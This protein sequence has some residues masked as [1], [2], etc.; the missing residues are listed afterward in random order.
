LILSVTLLL[1]AQQF[2]GD[3]TYSG[4]HTDAA[5][6]SAVEKSIA[7]GV[8]VEG[9]TPLN[10]E[11]FWG[12]FNVA[13]DVGGEVAKASAFYQHKIV[14]EKDGVLHVR[15]GSD[16]GIKV[17]LNGKLLLS[18]NI[19][20]G[21]NPSEEHI[22]LPLVDGEN[23][24]AIGIL[25][26]GGAWSFSINSE[27]SP[28]PIK[29]DRAI[30]KG[31]DWLI[32]NQL[33]DGSWGFHNNA[34]RN[35]ATSLAVYTL[36]SCGVSPQSAAVQKGLSYIS[37]TY[38]EK[39]YSAGC[40]LMALAELNDSRYYEQMEVIASDLIS[41][42]ERNGM[43]AYPSGHWDLS[44]TQFA[45]LG[46]RA[47][48]EIGIAVPAKVWRDAIEGI[49]LCG[50]QFD[51]STQPTIT[52]FKYYPNYTSSGTL[53]MTAAAIASIEICRQ[54]LDGKYPQKIRKKVQRAAS[55]GMAWM[56]QNFTVAQNF[57]YGSSHHYYTLYGIERV[58]AVHDITHFGEHNWYN[59]GA[60]FL[61]DGQNEDGYWQSDIASLP[62]TLYSL[63]FLKRATASAA[64]TGENDV[65]T[66]NEV[67]SEDLEGRLRLHVNNGDPAV[68]WTSLPAGAKSDSV[69]YF[70]KRARDSLWQKI[71]TSSAAKF[72]LSR[73][74]AE[75]GKWLVKA[76]CTIG[77][78]IVNSTDVTYFFVP[79]LGPNDTGYGDDAFENLIPAC[80]P[81]YEVS[82][83]NAD[84]FDGDKLFDGRHSTRWLTK[85][86]DKNPEFTISLRKTAKTKRLLFSHTYTAPINCTGA[87]RP[88][89]VAVYINKEE[90]PLIIPINP[91]QTQ[92]TIYTFSETVRIKKLRVVV[93]KV[94]GGTLGSSAIGFSEVELQY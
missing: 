6:I 93:T 64:I 83:R 53:S 75:P 60:G 16:D 58:G 9:F 49:L 92:K 55:E 56:T 81:S 23:Q 57:G 35:G 22:A 70:I 25:N 46:L 17:W 88:E 48:A 74:L 40:Q 85:P 54:Q 86:N 4:P 18:H 84:Y 14:A 34:Y 7:T 61:V 27:A 32:Q 39:T 11:W 59:N 28:N 80:R 91:D 12:T 3:W 44:C 21:L 38:P 43:W 87:A 72:A 50:A 45:I 65:S 94:I 26:T 1:Y 63:L 82:S 79:N 66:G 47:A 19:D 33:V 73:R 36:L 20:R 37:A 89:E 15:M 30:R 5:E 62:D 77:G 71:G 31:T 90:E 67:V 69:S 24:L 42:Q 29:V 52:G 10:V 76:E 2:V 8:S 78:Q 13:N 68:M 51:G 41:W